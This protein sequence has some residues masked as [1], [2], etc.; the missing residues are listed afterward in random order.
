M[1]NPFR[2]RRPDPVE[3]SRYEGMVIPVGGPESRLRRLLRRRW[4]VV[5]L[6]IAVLLGAL[7]G[8]GAY[9]YY[10]FQ[11]DLQEDLEEV[12]PEEEDQ[13]FNVLLVGSDSREGLTEEERE[14]LGADVVDEQGRA[15]TGER[16]DTLILG[17]IDPATNKV[18]MV[19]FPRDLYVPIADGGSNKINDALERG[20]DNLVATVKNLTGLEIHHYA[21]V[22]IAGFR[23]IVDAIGGITL[24]ITE[25]I[26]FDPQTGIQVTEEE[27]P[28]VEFDGER[29]LRFVRS[30]NFPEGDFRRIQNQQKFLSAA[31]S[32]VTSV[33]TLF[34]IGRIRRLL[35]AA[36]R[37]LR[38]D[39]HTTVKG[40]YD[41]G[42][43]FRSFDP[44]NY[45]AYTAPNLGPAQNEAGSVVLPDEGGMEIVFG[46][47]ADNISPAEA[48]DIPDV[49]PSE[50]RVSVLNGSETPG[51]ATSG[52]EALRAATALDEK[53]IQIAEVADAARRNF[54][55]HIVRYDPNDV[56]AFDKAR[57]IAAA[58][59]NSRMREAT[60]PEG[61]HVQV[62]V[63]KPEFRT[64]RVIQIRP[65]EI[66]PPGTEPEECR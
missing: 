13:P 19:Q 17:H 6:A 51:A 15:I 1:R 50:V 61:V 9:V 4:L 11:S 42:Q 26:P 59:P 40:L 3:A 8:F 28:L 22:N 45:E 36:G 48:D 30:R 49:D 44:E 60:T 24:C 27:L 56:D 14:R 65:I 47:L 43:R 41:I 64:E 66:P 46:A 62:V 21:Q 12:V 54:R 32:K 2:R 39:Q 57:L 16:A 33:G 35:R 53:V 25:P 31:I 37:N 34:D 23:D 52:A 58:I 18:I 7:A 63:G 55:R 38:M 20:K 10:S 29:A 5:S